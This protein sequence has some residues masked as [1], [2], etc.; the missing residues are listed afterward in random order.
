[1]NVAVLGRR[2][3]GKTTLC[4][5]M[6]GIDPPVKPYGTA[7]VNFMSCTVSGIN[8]NVWDCPPGLGR[9]FANMLH[10]MDALIVCYN[11]RCI[12][13]TIDALYTTYHL[14]IL[15]AVTREYPWSFLHLSDLYT[16]GCNRVCVCRSPEELRNAVYCVAN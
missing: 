3:T 13:G 15:V 7:T 2:G 10:T 9:H 1:M 11:G 14:P 12:C 16:T 6:V 8:M 5:K 4:Y